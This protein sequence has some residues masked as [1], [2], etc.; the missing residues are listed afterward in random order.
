MYGYRIESG[1]AV[2]DE[3][4]ACILNTMFHNYLNGM[5]LI[6]AAETAGLHNCHSQIKKMLQ[7]EIYLGDQYYPPI[8]DKALFALVQTEVEKRSAAHC[9]R[10]KKRCIEPS[11]LHDFCM[12]IP[13]KQFEN[14]AEQAEYLYSLIG[15]KENA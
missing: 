4:E 11:I 5:S 3:N 13:S 14:P 1:K 15:V 2:I 8:I 9:Q 7:R 12:G 10:G 6:E